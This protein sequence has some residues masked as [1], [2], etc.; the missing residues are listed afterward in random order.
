MRVALSFPGCHRRGGVER[1]VFE[2]A[3]YLAARQHRVTVLASEWEVD[4]YSSIRYRQVPVRTHPWFLR[5]RS[6]FN[7]CKEQLRS[8]EHDV[9]NTHGC[10]C[11]EGGVHWVQSLHKA[12][13][14]RSRQFRPS[15][16]A[17][18]LRQ[19]L[20]PV[21]RSLLAMEEQHFVGRKY[22]RIIATTPRV[23]EDLG[24]LYGVADDDVV[25]IPNGF[26]PAEFNPARRASRRDGMRQR[27]GLEA[28][29]VALVFVA[30]E[31]ERKG[32]GTILS[33][34]RQLGRTDLRLLVAGRV[35]R[36]RVQE[37]ARAFGVADRVLALGPSSDIG[38]LHA[39]GDLLVLPTQYEALCLSILEALGSGLPVVTSDVPGAVDAIRPGVN[40]AVVSDPT[41]GEE[42][43]AALVP[44]LDRDRREALSANAPGTVEAYRWPS[45]LGRYE[46]VLLE[47]A[48]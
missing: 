22:Q 32:Y 35:S 9:L 39:A 37:Q 4:G 14:E 40:G 15:L 30:N 42:L 43:A 46:Q 31:L 13:L 48:R 27:L 33:A 12:W 3:R 21:H 11:P 47:H 10:V 23:R 6:Y 28:D 38:A 44:L 36:A 5:G 1:V 17:A 7:S 8:T 19:R 26:A 41:S 2:C 25:V 34:L 18:G 24:R 29:Q 16:S 45:V 20:N